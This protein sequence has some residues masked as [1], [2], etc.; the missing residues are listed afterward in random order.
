MVSSTGETRM[1]RRAITATGTIPLTNARLDSQ[2]YNLSRRSYNGTLYY[3]DERLSARVSGAYRSPFIVGA[4]GTGNVFEGNNESLY[5]DASV[6]Y[7][8]AEFLT[9]SLEGINLTNE[10]TDRF[11]DQASNRVLTDTTFGRTITAGVR[12]GF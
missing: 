12:M 10:A 5:I 4:S 9:L 8:I 11:A 7:R 3:E 2:L 6:S 1:P